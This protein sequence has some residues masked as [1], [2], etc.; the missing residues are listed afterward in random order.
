MKQIVAPEEQ[1]RR[2]LIIAA[3]YVQPPRQ[4]KPYATAN[5]SRVLRHALI[6]AGQ[7][8]ETWEGAFFGSMPGTPVDTWYS[9]L[10]ELTQESLSDE[11]LLD[12]YGNLEYAAAHYTACSLTARGCQLALELLSKHPEWEATLAAKHPKDPPE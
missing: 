6:A 11:R 8:E 12:G 7:W 4:L 3:A 10:I 2:D 5:S 9:T 1:F